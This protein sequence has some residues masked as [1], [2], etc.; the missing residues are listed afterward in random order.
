MLPKRAGKVK[1]YRNGD[2]YCVPR[3]LV[4]TS[5]TTATLDHL[6][7]AATDIL[8][9]YPAVHRLFTPRGGTRVHSIQQV[10]DG[11]ALVATSNN[12]HRG[13]FVAIDYKGITSHRE[14]EI[15]YQ[16]TMAASPPK[17]RKRL[18]VPGRSL[19]VLQ[20][21]KP[22]LVTLLRNGDRTGFKVKMLLT[23][24]NTLTWGQLLQQMSERMKMEAPVRTVYTITGEVVR[25]IAD[26][27]T[28]GT[29]VCVGRIPFRQIGYRPAPPPQ[30]TRAANKRKGA[31]LPPISPRKGEPPRGPVLGRGSRPVLPPP[32]FGLASTG[33]AAG[34]RSFVD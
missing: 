7:D 6:M 4:L 5:R 30:A 13:K 11:C 19:E 29:Y 32:G 22:K 31:K 34:Y 1:V 26:L 16:R 17:P 14:R 25:N 24:R 2:P 10:S 12:V 15:S 3:T 18:P 20:A 28:G 23:R 33:G 21:N 27:K 8:Q 9:P